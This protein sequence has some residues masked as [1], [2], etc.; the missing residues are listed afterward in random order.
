MNIN[1]IPICNNSSSVEW[2]ELKMVYEMK[3][4]IN[5]I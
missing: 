3:L 5:V 1:E 2:I 4:K